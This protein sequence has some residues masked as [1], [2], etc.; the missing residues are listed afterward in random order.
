MK[1]IF[2]S[3]ANRGIGLEFTKQYLSEGAFVIACARNPLQATELQALLTKY[4]QKLQLISLDISDEMQ[5]IGL[6]SLLKDTAID[7]VICNAG[8]YGPKDER[9]QFASL[10]AVEWQKTLTINCIAQLKL[11][12]ILTNNLMLG[13]DKKIA[14][15]SSKMG[16]LDDNTSG[17]SY[18]YRSSKAAL[19]AACKSLSIDLKPDGIKV[20]ILHPGWV[21]TD[22]GGPNALI[23]TNQSVSGMK[24]IIQNLSLKNSGQFLSYDN[25]PIN[26]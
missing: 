12:E 25:Q 17:G 4:P 18:I 3:G 22:M 15:L 6:K 16:S 24:K 26:W 20:V 10:D 2:I 14:V 7:I 1:T 13:K 5:I 8:Y 9:S 23:T 19:N 11:L 21:Q